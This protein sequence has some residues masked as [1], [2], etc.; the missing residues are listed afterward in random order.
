MQRRRSWRLFC[1]TFLPHRSSSM[2]TA[3]GQ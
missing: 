2:G 3:S 1:C